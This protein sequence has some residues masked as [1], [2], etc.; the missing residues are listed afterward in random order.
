[1][2]YEG[3]Q[4]V[5]YYDH[6][7]HTMEFALLCDELE[8]KLLTGLPHSVILEYAQMIEAV[9]A[10]ERG[11]GEFPQFEVPK[12]ILDLESDEKGDGDDHISV[13]EATLR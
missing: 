4:K 2:E 6:N 10:W 8:C 1:M 7:T 12:R 11:E 5:T 3:Y 9:K 13:E